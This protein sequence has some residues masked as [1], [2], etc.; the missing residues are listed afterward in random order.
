MAEHGSEYSYS[1]DMGGRGKRTLISETILH[2][3]TVRRYL[4]TMKMKM[5]KGWNSAVIH[6][7]QVSFIQEYRADSHMQSNKQDSKHVNRAKFEETRT[8]RIILNTIKSI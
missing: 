8:R 1:Q 7:N 2:Y 3:Y 5:Q 4:G 6:D